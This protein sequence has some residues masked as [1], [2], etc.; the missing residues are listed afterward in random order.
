[1]SHAQREAIL[2]LLRSTRCTELLRGQTIIE[3]DASDSVAQGCQVGTWRVGG[4]RA[5]QLWRQFRL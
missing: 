5:G 3:I 1:M 2:E 4:R